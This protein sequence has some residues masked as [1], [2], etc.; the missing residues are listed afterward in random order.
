MDSGYRGTRE[1]R[2]YYNP[3]EKSAAHAFS[4]REMIFDDGFNTLEAQ[5]EL[6]RDFYAKQRETDQ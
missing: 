5:Q 2:P 3:E 1:D 4:D 6:Y